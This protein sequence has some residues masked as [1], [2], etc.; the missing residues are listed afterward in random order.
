M[1]DKQF[2][3]FRNQSYDLLLTA[4]SAVALGLFAGVWTRFEHCFEACY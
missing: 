3:P 1:L 2:F 4:W